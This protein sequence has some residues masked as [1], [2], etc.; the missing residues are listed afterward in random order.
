MDCLKTKLQVK[1]IFSGLETNVIPE[2]LNVK[3]IKVNPKHNGEVYEIIW[4]PVKNVNHG[5]VSYTVKVLE[6]GDGNVNS[7][8]SIHFEYLCFV[9]L[10]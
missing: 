2:E 9:L 3:M 8:V 4:E 5:M 10:H 7:L 1:N 6:N